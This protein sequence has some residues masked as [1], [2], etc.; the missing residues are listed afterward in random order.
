MDALMRNAQ[1][2]RGVSRAHFQLAAT[3]QSY[4]ASRGQRRALI[5]N[6]CVHQRGGVIVDRVLNC[7][8]ASTVGLAVDAKCPR[9]RSKTFVA[10]LLRTRRAERRVS[11]G[12][13][14]RAHHHRRVCRPR[15]FHARLAS[16]TAPSDPIVGRR[17][18]A[19]RQ[20]DSPTRKLM[21][22]T[23]PFTADE[24]V[25]ASSARQASGPA[26]SA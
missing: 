19:E 1:Q 15:R 7:R 10:C 13:K 12:H 18:R 3:Q 16:L 21:G 20:I 17:R 25:A 11:S 4:G 6:V 9:T 23:I 2:P 26:R 14:G 24:F 22:E 8:T 5:C